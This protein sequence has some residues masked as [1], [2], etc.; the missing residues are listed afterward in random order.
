MQIV[1]FLRR[2]SQ[3]TPL[4]K[5]RVIVFVFELWDFQNVFGIRILKQMIISKTV[6]YKHVAERLIINNLSNDAVPMTV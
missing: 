3:T 6:Q 5:V 4:S 2:K 1:F